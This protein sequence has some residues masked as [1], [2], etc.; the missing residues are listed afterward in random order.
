[1]ANFL[2]IKPQAAQLSI[3]LGKV[4]STAC[5]QGLALRTHTREKLDMEKESKKN[6]QPMGLESTTLRSRSL[7][8]TSVL[9]PL[10]R[11]SRFMI[12]THSSAYKLLS[13]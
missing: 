7:H 13:A 10:S 6:Q 4:R 11:D 5:L 12:R 8:S 3:F 9:Q 2:P 1:M